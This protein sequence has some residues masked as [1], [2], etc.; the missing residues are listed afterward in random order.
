MTKDTTTIQIS[1]KLKSKLD[2]LGKKNDTYEN[3]I[4]RLL[5]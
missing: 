5:K 3:I 4:E 2:K 1:F